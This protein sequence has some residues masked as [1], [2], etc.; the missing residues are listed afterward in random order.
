MARGEG[1]ASAALAAALHAGGRKAERVDAGEVVTTDG[2]H[3]AAAPD[4]VATRKRARRRLGARLRRGLAPV[5]PGFVGLGPDGSVTT[6][7]RGGSDLTATLLARALGAAR[8]VLWKDVPGIL[9]ADPKAVP[10]ARLIP[11]LHHREAAEVAYFGAK[12]LHPRALIPLDG[13]RITLDVRSFLA[14]ER[15]GTEVSARRTLEAYPVKALATIKGQTLVTV[16][17]KGMMGVPGIAARTFTAV[18]A[19]SL[20]VSPIFQASPE[21]SIGF[22]LPARDAGKAVVAL[23]RA[24]REELQTGLIDGITARPDLPVVAPCGRPVH[25]TPPPP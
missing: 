13:S 7:G 23:R 19:E 15:P 14:P 11:Q 6:L 1:G 17:G 8:V 20:S 22:T 21:S 12:V 9:T 16:A 2:R 4:L 18:H 5:V 25:R 10:D 3:G 24:F